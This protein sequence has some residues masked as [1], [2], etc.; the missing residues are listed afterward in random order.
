MTKLQELYETREKLQNLGIEPNAD[1]ERQLAA[2]EEEI[3][4]NEI[5]PIITDTVEP[6][7]KQVKREVVLVVEHHPEK[8]VSVHLSRKRNITNALSDAV[9]LSNSD[10]VSSN[11]YLPKLERNINISRERGSGMG[12]A[13]RLRVEFSDGTVI[14]E[15]K[16]VDT[17]KKAILK[18]GVERVAQLCIAPY[19]SIL[20]LNKVNLVTKK[21][22]PQYGNRQHEVGNG[23]LVFTCS[24]TPS[25]KRQIEAIAKALGIKV[26]VKIV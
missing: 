12:K 25:K 6:V 14:S 20:Q 22:D 10:T 1:L 2:L 13:T 5:V 24:N 8:G 17:L 11:K 19:D 16:A 21:R 26:T 18:F 15:S 4:K 9:T 7:L 23:W 3:I